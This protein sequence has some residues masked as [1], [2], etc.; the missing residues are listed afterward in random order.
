VKV[1]AAIVVPGVALL[2]STCRLYGEDKSAPMSRQDIEQIVQEYIQQHPEVI[3]EAVR[4]HQE[5]ERIAAQQRS[6]EAI[7]A[8]HHELFEETASPV[9]G[10]ADAEVAIVEFFDYNCGYC[11]RVAPTLTKLLEENNVRLIFKDLPILGP[12]SQIA[13]RAA[14]A[15]QRQ[16]AYVAFHRAL[17][18]L[19]SPAT[20][21]AIEEISRTLGLDAARLKTDMDSPGIRSILAQNQ[22]LAGAIGVR[23]TPSFVVGHELVSGAMDLHGFQAL[24]NKNVGRVAN[25]A[26]TAGERTGSGTQDT[27]APNSADRPARVSEDQ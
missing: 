15:A 3:I 9:A 24:I 22:Q 27:R 7:L 19:K 13:A 17:M 1:N 18:D 5:R 21:E 14:L 8:K 10:K 16:G 6:G 25:A 4:A 2:L 26:Q 23:S 12:G 20:T 11:R